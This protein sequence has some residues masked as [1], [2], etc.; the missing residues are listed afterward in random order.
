MARHKRKIDPNSTTATDD[1]GQGGPPA[2]LSPAWL[3]Q[4]YRK[5]GVL[6]LAVALLLVTGAAIG[7]G[8]LDAIAEKSH[9]GAMPGRLS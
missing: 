5:Y 3:V 7:K 2:K 1:D 9:Q 8:A 4:G 6:G